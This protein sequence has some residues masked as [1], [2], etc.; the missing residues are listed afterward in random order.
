MVGDILLS[1]HRNTVRTFDET[2]EASLRPRLLYTL[3]KRPKHE[4]EG[5]ISNFRGHVRLLSG[6]LREELENDRFSVNTAIGFHIR[7]YPPGCLLSAADDDG[8]PVIVSHGAWRKREIRDEPFRDLR[9]HSICSPLSC[10][11][12]DLEQTFSALKA[13]TKPRR[14]DIF[15]FYFS[16][17][18][19]HPFAD[20]NGTTSAVLADALCARHGL[21]PLLALNVRF[22]DKAYLWSLS[23]EYDQVR[24]EQALTNLLGKFDA[25]NRGQQW[26]DRS[27]DN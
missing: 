26:T 24:S 19:V 1:S 25:F 5:L 12:R 22:K 21:A 6:Y 4:H 9:W 17:L 14:E 3:G 16:F 2:I 8:N 11:E 10:V 7:L 18:R 23:E 13:I 15:R 27:I 20:S